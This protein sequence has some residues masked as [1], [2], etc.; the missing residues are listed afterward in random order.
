M[1]CEGNRRSP[2]KIEET[3]C[4]RGDECELPEVPALARYRTAA[5]QHDEDLR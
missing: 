2:E 5:A 3:E 4:E 1:V